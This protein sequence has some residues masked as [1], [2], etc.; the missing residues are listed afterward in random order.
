MQSLATSDWTSVQLVVTRR[1]NVNLQSAVV[2]PLKRRGRH[3]PAGMHNNASVS[4]RRKSPSKPGDPHHATRCHLSP[5][6]SHHKTMQRDP[7]RKNVQKVKGENQSVIVVID[8]ARFPCHRVRLECLSTCGEVNGASL[9]YICAFPVQDL[10]LVAWHCLQALIG[11]TD[12]S[13]TQ[14]CS[15]CDKS[16]SQDPLHE[17]TSIMAVDSFNAHTMA[18]CSN[19]GPAASECVVVA[20]DPWGVLCIDVAK[21]PSLTCMHDACM[22]HLDMLCCKKCVAERRGFC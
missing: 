9:L 4:R 22:T 20:E 6:V 11:L 14:W 17:H 2:Q 7:T 21:V 19:H 16:H 12:G 18:T 13:L 1:R 3:P 10:A 8:S 15:R 5:P